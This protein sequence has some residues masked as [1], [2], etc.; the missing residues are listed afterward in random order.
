MNGWRIVGL[1]K[2]A[3]NIPIQA[4]GWS[5]TWQGDQTT[6]EDYPEAQSVLAGL[7]AVA[8]SDFTII[9]G[10]RA[11]ANVGDYDVAIAVIGETPYAEMKGDLALPAP[12]THSLRHPEDLQLMETMAKSGKPVVTVLLSGRTA[13]VNDLLNLSDAFVAAWLPGTEGAGIA[14]V[15]LAGAGGK[16]RHDF[17]GRSSFPWPGD[18]CVTS[19]APA[20]LAATPPQFP[21]GYGLSYAR[22]KA[23]PMLSVSTAQS[24]GMR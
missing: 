8:G 6:N 10:T 13:Y 9:D 12:T 18:P 22:P 2:G 24:C 4:G 23:V 21:A 7:R 19:F 17:R 3:D 16:P 1:G 15:L 20:T 11:G 5:L 14:D